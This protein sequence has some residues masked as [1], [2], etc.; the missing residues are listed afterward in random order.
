[1]KNI[2]NVILGLGMLVASSTNSFAGDDKKS[3][4]SILDELS[5]NTKSYSSISA[6][7]SYVVVGKDKKTKDNQTMNIKVK[8]KKFR[9]NIPGNLIVSNGEKVWNK[10]FESGE[11]V[12]K[13]GEEESS[14]NPSNIFTMYEKGYS[15]SLSKTE[16][17]GK[18]TTYIIKMVPEK[19]NKMDSVFLYVDGS[20]KK[21][22]KMK[23]FMTNGNTETY[24]IKKFVPNSQMAE[25]DFVY[26]TS[27]TPK[28]LLIIE[29]DG[30]DH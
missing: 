28:D 7:L 10:S 27:K 14:M 1:M 17:V 22:L 23:K 13:C 18:N 25:S 20:K 4:K 9:L 8:G 19:K 5:K 30:K 24:E 2:L 15:Y 3:A 16:K 29:C 21:I 11:V 26:D 12:V 6:E